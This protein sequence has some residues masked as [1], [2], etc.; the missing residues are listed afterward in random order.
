[1]PENTTTRSDTSRGER[2]ERS[3]AE[4][5]AATMP[6]ALFG[7]MGPRNVKAAL[8]LQTEMFDA[9]HDIGRDWLERATS[10][11]E[12]AFKLPSKLTAAQ[13][14]PDAF[15]AYQEWL[16]EWMNMCSEDSRRF[17]SDSQKLVDKSVS[18]FTAASPSGSG[19][20]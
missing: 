18:C 16:S 15:S 7:E 13:S 3:R 14:V 11:A 2:S 4:R 8:R 12:L 1:M 5:A 17:I 20:T 6:T 19:A 9:L 10:E